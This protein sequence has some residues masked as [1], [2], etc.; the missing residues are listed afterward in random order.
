MERIYF[1]HNST[2]PLEPR[3]LEAMLPY[4]RETFGNASSVHSFG[5]FAKAG[6]EQSRETI[7]DLLNCRP[8]EIY[9]TSGGTES[10][11]T[12]IKGVADALGH[13]GKH[14]ITSSVEHHAVLETC[15]YLEKHGYDVTFLPVDR[16]GYINPD[17]LKDALRDD[18]ILVAI[19]LGNNETGT[20]QDIKKLAEIAHARDIY[21]HTDA[22]QALGKVRVDIRE[23]GVDL[24]A[25]S[26]HKFYGP[27][28]VG[29]L[30]AKAG[31]RFT[32]YAH[33]GAHER[34]KRAGTENVAAIVGMAKAL[35]LDLAEMAANTARIEKLADKLYDGVLTIPDV[36]FN[37]DP[38][39]R[40]KGTL[41]FT[42][43]GCE[44]EATILSLDMKGIAVSS[45]SAC[46]SGAVE[47]SHVLRAMGV[48]AELAQTAI[49]FSLG[50]DNT[51]A[52][53]DYTLEQLPAIINRLRQMSPIYAQSR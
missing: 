25:G 37:G 52:Q 6:L 29:I 34:G 17:E 53:V 26:A 22:V 23:L 18:T 9:F 15:E 13:K 19:M 10:D 33:G 50:K 36:T 45:G 43:M 42:F 27:K 1:D 32:P 21:F 51:E 40:I 44:G 16:M 8:E 11:N 49:R 28:G 4:L 35:E 38:E 24:L 20:L 5:Q 12:A 7:A 30:Y 47:P 3:A 2:T 39:N 48:P 31:T 46:T 14:I 41:N